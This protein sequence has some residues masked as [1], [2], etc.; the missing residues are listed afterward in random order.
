M[1]R[2]RP[3]CIRSTIASGRQA[4]SSSPAAGAGQVSGIP[5]RSALPR[6]VRPIRWIRSAR[7]VVAGSWVP[8]FGGVA[9]RWRGQARRRVTRPAPGPGSASQCR[10]Q[11]RPHA[12]Q[13][14][15][16]AKAEAQSG[17]GN[18]SGRHVRVGVIEEEEIVHT[19]DLHHSSNGSWRT[20]DR[21]RARFAG[22][23]RSRTQ[24]EVQAAA[25][26][27]LHLAQGRAR[28]RRRSRGSPCRARASAADWWRCR[29]RRGPSG[30][31]RRHG[32]SRRFRSRVARRVARGR[33]LG[34]FSGVRTPSRSFAHPPC[35]TNACPVSV[36]AGTRVPSRETRKTTCTHRA[37]TDRALPIAL[38]HARHEAR[39]GGERTRPSTLPPGH[40]RLAGG[41]RRRSPRECRERVAA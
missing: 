9:V 28:T 10:R 24:H 38:R 15:T 13:C 7:W 36:I 32:R 39:V 31:A 18:E 21:Q 5:E 35:K 22:E 26:Q 2:R 30:R 34:R 20:H 1:E 14:R 37:T 33:L 40:V 19:R 16:Q 17:R 41:L 29:S 12:A 8:Q 3:E 23:R 4:C 11:A 6:C 27:E 25:V